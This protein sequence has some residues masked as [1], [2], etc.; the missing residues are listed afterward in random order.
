MTRVRSLI[1]I[2]TLGAFVGLFVIQL[3]PVNSTLMKV[4]TIGLILGSWLGL[5]TLVWGNQ[6]I[7]RGVFALSL[8]VVVVFLL[9]D[10]ELDRSEIRADYLRRIQEFEGTRYYWGGESSHGIDC[11][12]LT[13]RAYRDAL[14]HYGVRKIDGGSLR[15]WLEQWWFDASA[16][17]LGEGYR[18][19][20]VP[21]GVTGA[22]RS[23][24]VSG[25]EPGDLAVTDGGAH[26]LIYLGEDQWI[27]ADPGLGKVAILHGK[28][29]ENNWFKIPV[30]TH[31]W[32]VFSN[33]E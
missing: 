28:K 4:I 13:R 6:W 7:R 30:H 31:R 32:Q 33:G 25:L 20:T 21:L 8:L 24:D 14:L 27:Q 18:D 16:R 23:M 10:R 9:P 29:D 15:L 2:G 19:Y 1:L 12:G 17:A 22:I 5:L 26:I 11:S 3:N